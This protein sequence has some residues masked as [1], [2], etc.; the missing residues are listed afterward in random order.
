[1]P[2]ESIED[3]KAERIFLQDAC[4]APQRSEI[5]ARYAYRRFVALDLPIVQEDFPPISIVQVDLPPD[6]QSATMKS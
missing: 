4:Y 2:E 1:M 5:D 6:A 3:I